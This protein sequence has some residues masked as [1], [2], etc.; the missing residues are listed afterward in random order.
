VALVPA[1]VIQHVLNTAIQQDTAATQALN[2]D[3]T[4]L[5]NQ[6]EQ[7][8]VSQNHPHSHSHAAC[9]FML[10]CDYVIT[11]SLLAIF[12]KNRLPT[13]S[14]QPNTNKNRQTNAEK[15]YTD[16]RGALSVKIQLTLTLIQTY[17][18]KVLRPILIIILP[19]GKLAT[20]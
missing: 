7:S 3:F 19:S 17:P 1:C 16:C 15:P 4:K 12:L 10:T 20:T 13:Y 2:A 5:I 11:G 14:G 6:W 8:K 18:H 9:T